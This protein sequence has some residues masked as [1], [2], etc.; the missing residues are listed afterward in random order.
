MS[1]KVKGWI[2]EK[3]H[4]RNYKTNNSKCHIY[5]KIYALGETWDGSNNFG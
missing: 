3:K 5:K 4:K 2:K 1:V